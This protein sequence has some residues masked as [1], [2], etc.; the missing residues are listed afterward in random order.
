MGSSLK[1][2]APRK[3]ALSIDSLCFRIGGGVAL[4]LVSLAI[5]LFFWGWS[6]DDPWI[7]YRYAGN[8]VAGEG[9]VFNPGDRL[10]CYSSFTHVVIIALLKIGGIEPDFPN[11]VLGVLCHVAA[12]AALALLPLGLRVLL[13]LAG[14]REGPWSRKAVGA[15]TEMA[16]QYELL[17]RRRAL[18][19]A[20]GLSVGVRLAKYTSWYLLLLAVVTNRPDAPATGTHS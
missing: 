15:V 7:T 10:E 12:V 11:R 20:F 13:R 17:L 4:A 6:I 2:D 19:P 1:M 18:W 5:C 16:S 3:P 9:L 8:W 14:G